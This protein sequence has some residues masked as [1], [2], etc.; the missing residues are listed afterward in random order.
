[1]DENVYILLNIFLVYLIFK[2]D[3][4]EKYKFFFKKFLLKYVYLINNV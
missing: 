1:M 4:N 2:K 3:I